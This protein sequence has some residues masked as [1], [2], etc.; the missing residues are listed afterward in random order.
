MWSWRCGGLR[1]GW[2]REEKEREQWALYRSHGL[3]GVN[4]VAGVQLCMC[5]SASDIPF[6]FWAT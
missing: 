6:R 3:E 5:Y 4:D 2:V 1:D